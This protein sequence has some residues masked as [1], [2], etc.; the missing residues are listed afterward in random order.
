MS[1]NTKLSPWLSYFSA[2]KTCKFSSSVPLLCL[3]IWVSDFGKKKKKRHCSRSVL[4]TGALHNNTGEHRSSQPGCTFPWVLPAFGSHS[5]SRTAF[6]TAIHCHTTSS[7]LLALQKSPSLLLHAQR[8]R[9]SRCEGEERQ[10]FGLLGLQNF[11]FMHLSRS[12]GTL[13]LKC[14]MQ[15]DGEGWSPQPEQRWLQDGVSASAG[16]GGHTTSLWKQRVQQRCS[17]TQQWELCLCEEWKIPF[18]GCLDVAII[19]DL[20]SHSHPVW[21]TSFF[22]KPISSSN[23]IRQVE[24]Y[25]PPVVWP[26]PSCIYCPWKLQWGNVV[27]DNTSC[28]TDGTTS[29]F[30]S[31]AS[32]TGLWII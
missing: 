8:G 4:S 6:Q 30:F 23:L 10:G 25:L 12:T 7:L 22:S 29:L 27:L 16:G 19:S 17:W 26:L 13:L 14:C 5:S 9:V 28:K 21:T 31:Q 3:L 15:A 18:Y 20:C 1:W 2:E 11:Q 24:T 32:N